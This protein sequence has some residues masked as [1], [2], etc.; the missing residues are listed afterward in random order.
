MRLARASPSRLDTTWP[1]VDRYFGLN[2]RI[3]STRHPYGADQGQSVAN[4][5]EVRRGAGP[6]LLEVGVFCCP[7]KSLPRL[8]RSLRSICTEGVVLA[9]NERVLSLDHLAFCWAI[10]L[11]VRA[12]S[13]SSGSDPPSRISS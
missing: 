13:I 2:I 1:H 11:S 10:H 5:G 6:R 12:S 4:R 8:A 9:G 7:P 3:A